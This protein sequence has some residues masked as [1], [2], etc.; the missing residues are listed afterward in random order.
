MTWLVRSQLRHIKLFFFQS[1]LG[2]QF[3]MNWNVKPVLGHSV[4]SFL[5]LM[6]SL[7]H[8]ELLRL[9][10]CAAFQPLASHRQLTSSCLP[11]LCVPPV[12]LSLVWLACEDQSCVY[13][14]PISWSKPLLTFALW[15]WTTLES[16]P[17]PAWQLAAH[18]WSKR[19]E[20]SPRL[21]S[22]DLTRLFQSRWSAMSSHDIDNKSKA[23]S[24][25]NAVRWLARAVKSSSKETC[26]QKK[27]THVCLNMWEIHHQ[28]LWLIWARR[29]SVTSTYRRTLTTSA[30][31]CSYLWKQLVSY[32]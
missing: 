5:P 17:D 4:P 27:K 6:S 30:I 32:L 26:E 14:L 10:M 2:K 7:L 24:G 15:H 21:A 16:C 11:T 28:H 22:T 18:N 19:G 20:K 1:K 23:V 13:L 31:S 12:F 9:P 25:M 3:R 8:P 29:P